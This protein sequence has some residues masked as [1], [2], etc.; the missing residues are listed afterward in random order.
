M[1]ALPAAGRASA[2]IFWPL[3]GTPPRADVAYREHFALLWAYWLWGPTHLANR[4]APVAV[5]VHC[6]NNVVLAEVNNFGSR[7]VFRMALIRALYSHA[8]TVVTT[9]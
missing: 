1:A 5:T 9:L 3:P 6:D 7:N 4:D 8:A 2:V